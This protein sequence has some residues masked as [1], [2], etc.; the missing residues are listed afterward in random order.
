MP[1]LAI[2]GAFE[3]ALRQAG[4]KPGR[5]PT[6]IVWRAIWLALARLNRELPLQLPAAVTT[7]FEHVDRM[8]DRAGELSKSDLRAIDPT[9]VAAVRRWLRGQGI[10]EDRLRDRHRPP[11]T[12]TP[13][14][15]R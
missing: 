6:T 11:R 10:D 14:K 7:V 9:V 2:A 13:R 5:G 12:L 3:T 4:K 15:P 8:R 1:A